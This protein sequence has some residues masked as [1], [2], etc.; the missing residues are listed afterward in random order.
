[1]LFRS[2]DL[3][4][5]GSDQHR[6]WFHTSLL[7]SCGTRGRAPFNAVLTHGFVL[8]EQARKMSKSL[9][10]VVAPQ[11]VTNQSG[12]DILRLW[13]VASDY[14]QDLSIGPN[15]LKQMSDLYRRL[16]NTMRYLLGNLAGFNEAERISYKEMPELERWVLHRVWEL[17]KLM[18]NACASYDFHG[19]FNELHN[20]C[21]VELSAFYFDT[22]KDALYCDAPTSARRRACRTVLDTL[23]NCLVTWLAPITCFTAEEAWLARHPGEDSSVHMQQFPTI[24][25]EWRDQALADKWVKVRTL[26]RVITGALEVERA[27]KKIG[28]SLQGSPRVWAPA[29][30]LAAVQGLPMEDISITSAITITEGTPPAGAYTLPDVPGAGVVVDLAPGEKCVRCWKVLPDVGK[31]KHPGVCERCSDAVDQLSAAAE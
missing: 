26:R 2:A 9:G 10:N 11:D 16:R 20:F 17:D 14:S 25:D 29:D 8:D 22:R 12:A 1:M 27:A 7:E 3:Y 4:L 15:I 31:H 5:E 6:G 28:A 18:R 21:A 30:L 13:V 24:P 19:L 23:Y